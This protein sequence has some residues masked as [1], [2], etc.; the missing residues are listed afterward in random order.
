VFAIFGPQLI[1]IL[2]DARYAEAGWMLQILSIRAIAQTVMVTTERVLLAYGDSFR[3]M[4]S[5]LARAIF[6][7]I[8]MYV[9]YLFSGIQG[10]LIGM[11]V[12]SFCE[13]IVL[14]ILINHYRVWLPKIDLLAFGLSAG[15]ISLGMYLT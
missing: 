4:I 13:Y 11:A 10:F 14:A 7:L 12:A 2:Y 5:Q 3:H 8:G 15:A 1:N 9:G 6:M